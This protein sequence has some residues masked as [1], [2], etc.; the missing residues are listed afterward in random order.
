MSE[1]TST[2]YSGI[3]AYS[4]E[5]AQTASTRH[6]NVTDP[7]SSKRI[8]FYKSGDPQFNGIKMVVSNRSFKT[9][10]AL[11]D[12]LSKRVPLPFGVRNISTPRGIHQVSKL[13]ELEDG[14]SYVCSHQKKI[15]PINL[16]KASKKPLLW[17]SSRPISARRRVVQLLRQNE[18][19]P[20]P[21]DN[22][23]VLGLSKKLV[24]FK[25]G[26][27]GFKHTIVLHKKTTKTF[28]SFLDH[29]T[30]VM[31]CPII[32]LYTADGRRIFGIQALLLSSGAV[33]AAGREPFK[34]GNYDLAKESL[35]LRLP[36]IT[37]RVLPKSKDKAEGQHLLKAS[38]QTASTPR[39]S[40]HSLSSDKTQT[41][42]TNCADFPDAPNNDIHVNESLLHMGED[43]PMMHSE[44][45][46]EK[47]V[48]VNPDGTMTVE[49]K[50]RLRIKSDETIQW[51][52]TV[53]RANI[54]SKS[55]RMV[56]STTEP[57]AESP[58][59]NRTD[60]K[61]KEEV[62]YLENT[63]HRRDSAVEAIHY[64]EQTSEQGSDIAPHSPV[65]PDSGSALWE[66]CKPCASRPPTPG[67]RKTRQTH[68]VVKSI[69]S[70]SERKVR[71]NVKQF[72]YSE[73]DGESKSEFHIVT[74]SVSRR[75]SEKD[76][77]DAN[78]KD[79]ALPRSLQGNKEDEMLIHF[80]RKQSSLREND[81]GCNVLTLQQDILTQ[82]LLEHV[83]GPINISPM[84]PYASPQ[85]GRPR[86]AGNACHHQDINDLKRSQSASAGCSELSA[87][88]N[89]D[90]SVS[91]DC[92]PSSDSLNNSLH[93]E[94][95][96]MKQETSPSYKMVPESQI[97]HMASIPASTDNSK[98]LNGRL[99][100]H[101]S[102]EPNCK[103]PILSAGGNKRKKKR[104]Q[105]QP[106]QQ[107]GFYDQI[108][109]SQH[110]T[111]EGQCEMKI[112][113]QGSIL[114]DKSIHE[115]FK[116]SHV[117]NDGL[118]QN[119]HMYQADMLSD[120]KAQSICSKN[121]MF[122]RVGETT[123]SGLGFPDYQNIKGKPKGTKQMAKVKPR[124]VKKI[125]LPPISKHDGALE[126]S[127]CQR[128]YIKHTINP[129]DSKLEGGCMTSDSH[130]TLGSIKFAEG[131]TNYYPTHNPLLERESSA[132]DGY[133]KGND[134]EATENAP[135]DSKKKRKK[136]KKSTSLGESK[137]K[138]T[139]NENKLDSK[140]ASQC[141]PEICHH[142]L[143]SYVQSWLQNIFPNS[144]L[145]AHTLNILTAN[146]EADKKSN[147]PLEAINVCSGTGMRLPVQSEV[148][149]TDCTAITERHLMDEPSRPVTEPA[150]SAKGSITEFT[151]QQVGSMAYAVAATGKKA[152][153]LSHLTVGQDANV[154]EQMLYDGSEIDGMKTKLKVD[155]QGINIAIRMHTVDVA[156]QADA[157]FVCRKHM[158]NEGLDHCTPDWLVSHQ[159]SSTP[160][161]PKSGAQCPCLLRSESPQH[162]STEAV[163]SSPHLLL[164]WLIVLNLKESLT[165][166][167]QNGKPHQNCSSAGI[168]TLLQSLK[169]IA[170]TENNED[171]KAAVLS[172]QESTLNY[173][174][175]NHDARHGSG[176][177]PTGRFACS[178]LTDVLELSNEFKM[179]PRGF[180]NEEEGDPQGLPEEVG[181]TG[182][183]LD[184]TNIAIAHESTE[185]VC[186]F[187][188]QSGCEHVNRDAR[189]S[190]TELKKDQSEKGCIIGYEGS[191]VDNK[192]NEKS[193]SI[194][195][196]DPHSLY[197]TTDAKSEDNSLVIQNTN[198]RISNV[199]EENG[200][201]K[202]K[203]CTEFTAE[204]KS[205]EAN[206]FLISSNLTIDDHQSDYL[207]D[208]KKTS[209]M[210]DQA[211]NVLSSPISITH[212]SVSE[213]IIEPETEPEQK[214]STVK[215]IVQ[216]ME[217]RKHSG[218][219][220]EFRKCLQS[221]LSSDWSDY[222]QD[223][224]ESIASDSTG[225]A[226]SEINTESGE[227][228]M[229]EKPYKTGLVKR[230]IE[231]LYGKA[232]ASLKS[233][234]S[235]APQPS[236]E[237]VASDPG[238]PLCLESQSKPNVSRPSS[239]SS[240]C[241]KKQN[242]Y[243]R[244]NGIPKSSLP[245]LQP[246]NSGEVF[247]CDTNDSLKKCDPVKLCADHEPKPRIVNE[248]DDGVLI[249]KGRWLLWENHL[250]RRS[251]PERTGM[252]G[253]L[254]TTSADT[255]LDNTSDDV[256]YSHF[257]NQNQP[258]PTAEISSSE[259]EDLV[260]PYS[261]R[262]NYFS[263]PHGSDSEPFHDAS[264]LKGTRNCSTVAAP[265]KKANK[266]SP[267]SMSSGP[268]NTIGHTAKEFYLPGNKVH[269]QGPPSN[270]VGDEN[271]LTESNTQN[272]E[273]VK[274]QDSM[275]RLHLV[276]GQ[277]CPIL[278]AII[279]AT[280]E[281][282]RGFAYCKASDIENQLWLHP[283][284]KETSRLLR[285]AAWSSTD[286]NNNAFFNKNSIRTHMLIK[287]I[288]DRLYHTRMINL[289]KCFSWKS[290]SLFWEKET[291]SI[292]TS[293]PTQPINAAVEQCCPPKEV[294]LNGGNL[295][296]QVRTD[297]NNNGSCQQL[298]TF[299]WLPTPIGCI[300]SRTGTV[301]PGTPCQNVRPSENTATSIHTGS[302]ENAD[303]LNTSAEDQEEHLRDAE[304]NTDH[305]TRGGKLPFI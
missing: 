252:Y 39:S 135:K 78:G 256:P 38:I 161:L 178:L 273:Q 267:A 260:K 40:I 96:I 255:M 121:G 177:L 190:I 245:V 100:N 218:T 83:D 221:P 189:R 114:T 97:T 238:A 224:E 181:N 279:E 129:L 156:V 180:S 272:R 233:S 193:A 98:V 222:R 128:N 302:S 32:K 179:D 257:K 124:S 206:V 11:L 88:N 105:A 23:V 266:V 269:P 141:P 236:P 104:S 144:S 137:N 249:E 33:V 148:C 195:Q 77:G 209:G 53:S 219:P 44:D 297:I 285:T 244:V 13:E 202:E 75:P 240:T 217:H 87:S 118:S 93:Q 263:M 74:H 94:D 166:I 167:L 16:E 37:R 116:D 214:R 51:T 281:E 274:E 175:E 107:R 64:K 261:L 111:E 21:R 185:G 154:D 42:N 150:A 76:N 131:M 278:T 28:E 277:H 149:T 49:M 151:E 57:G 117:F 262:C 196:E 184:D 130:N 213:H 293:N 243:C 58:D 101:V 220:F 115:A 7:T 27:T 146:T 34:P 294:G 223:S 215:M 152:E 80:G 208:Q 228:T 210:G 247:N 122:P 234:N 90:T 3:Q 188:D 159:Q 5:S 246:I 56:C 251:P 89:E 259:V 170:T 295:Q 9:F 112:I 8:C 136:N 265:S 25:N 48:H 197:E 30:E 291:N 143:E 71:E 162:A 63:Q 140:P 47:S 211:L 299:Q 169:Q 298:D 201:V 153:D 237:I 199:T 35:P 232:E 187:S 132:H 271:Q 204:V 242:Q 52:T 253:N 22:T 157:E 109:K 72:S 290:T 18:V 62:L 79:F 36:G 15:K 254:D 73:E 41:I 182:Y 258:L 59:L 43:L 171:L 99:G 45:D 84:M 287:S 286:E 54:S 85:K 216:E 60:H 198:N 68:A 275:D 226:S 250:V 17:Q 235:V 288:F 108:N 183:I 155:I 29:M 284:S 65:D 92:V 229:R 207:K 270:G 126:E 2:S 276:C 26:D 205:S 305:N 212:Q 296:M 10:D 248:E 139:V 283:V 14:K 142:S 138:M 86:S 191:P 134:V 61:T 300:L 69:T 70:V 282:S 292:V 110:S 158:E 165:N 20:A 24:I 186:P 119:T 241:Q 102:H 125:S 268:T 46:I 19:N 95:N 163:R 239:S 120:E 4:L 264:H 6:S 200:K 304:S 123:N 192:I 176:S 147:T 81:T 106:V 133:Q 113:S 231:R 91:L 31:Q 160:D 55:N 227:E 301:S 82:G 172:L 103:E 50:I 174:L 67:H 289:N 173:E 164:A 303:S 203:H 145:H 168:L 225:K 230:A 280:H 1:S 12:S 127:N 66:K 194:D